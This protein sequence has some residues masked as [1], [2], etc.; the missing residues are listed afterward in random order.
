MAGELSRRIGEIGERLAQDFIKKL[1]WIPAEENIDIKCEYCTEHQKKEDT[2]RTS[3]GIDFIVAYDCPLVP[4]TRRNI[5]IS[6]KNSMQEKTKGEVTK[7][8]DDL[9]ELGWAMECYKRSSLKSDINRYS[10]ASNVEDVGIL[11][12]IN[13]DKDA[14]ESFLKNLTNKNRMETSQ[15]KEIHFIENKRF[16]H[17]DLALS[18]LA[19]KRYK[20]VLNYFYPMNNQAYAADVAEIEGL[21]IPVQHLIASPLTFKYTEGDLKEFIV[22]SSSEFDVGTLERL[23]G[24]ANGC[25]QGWAGKITIIFP[26]LT[27]EQKESARKSYRGIKSTQ[28]AATIEVESLDPRAR[29]SS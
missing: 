4:N 18:Y 8:K 28:L 10:N 19:F 23:I 14:S 29:M 24:L 22:I 9:K 11:I 3:H 6:M 27:E 5:L 2:N 26:D 1:H 20:G 13:K 21:L 25:S 17:V 12:K 7:V 16:D 15:D